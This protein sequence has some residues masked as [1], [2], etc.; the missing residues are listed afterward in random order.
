MGGRPT[1]ADCNVPEE[2]AKQITVM[3]RGV[4]LIGFKAD[5]L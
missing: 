1:E 2:S 3:F 4:F 5:R